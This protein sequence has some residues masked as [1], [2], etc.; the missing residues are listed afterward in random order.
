MMAGITELYRVTGEARLLTY[1]RAWL[2]HHLEQGYVIETDND[3]PTALVAAFLYE[4]TGDEA[5][6]QVVLDVLHYLAFDALRTEQGGINHT[7]IYRLGR[8]SIWLDSLFMFGT[9]VNRWT[10][11][12]GD[13]EAIAVYREQL[14]IFSEVLQQDSGLFLHSDAVATPD[15]VIYWAR[16]N[17]WVTA[18]GYDYLRVLRLQGQS[19][20]AARAALS[21]QLDAV[22]ATQDA[23]SGR[24]WTLMTHPGE[25]YEETS[26][27]AL[28]A[29]GMAR[30]WRYSYLDDDVLVP[31]W[32]AVDGVL[33]KIERNGTGQ[34]VITDI[35]GPTN[36]GD[37]ATYANVALGDD[38]SFGVG[39][40]LLM[41]VETSG[42]ERPSTD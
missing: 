18:S 14:A 32:A 27:T 35:S 28:F 10:E 41:L 16:G 9:V 29:Y 33:E 1:V 42:L 38:I 23:N 20:P 36:A 39:A 25:V 19:D 13:P 40:T 11:V 12:T 3:C 15:P 5:Y 8:P 30:G 21:R 22:V 17:A 37:Y 6:R 2:D 34:P 24:W 31:M 7:G 4:E 26:A